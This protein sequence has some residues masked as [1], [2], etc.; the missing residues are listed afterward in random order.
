MKKE[1]LDLKQLSEFTK[2]FHKIN[3]YIIML[4]SPYVCHKGWAF[5]R[6]YYIPILDRL[7]IWYMPIIVVTVIGE[8]Q[9]RVFYHES[10]FFF[11]FVFFF[12]LVLLCPVKN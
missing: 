1:N 7:F 12:L 8:F 3:G 10:I 6:P 9:H 11:N 2:L 5:L 4:F